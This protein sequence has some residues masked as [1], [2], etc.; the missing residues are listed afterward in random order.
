[1]P[2]RMTRMLSTS[3]ASPASAAPM[4]RACGCDTDSAHRAFALWTAAGAER[5]RAAYER[6]VL[7]DAEVGQHRGADVARL[8]DQ[9]GGTAHTDTERAA[10]VIHGYDELIDV[11]EQRI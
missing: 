11:R 8:V 2:P 1:M 3:S 4:S 6:L 7:G 9:V 10:Y 5:D